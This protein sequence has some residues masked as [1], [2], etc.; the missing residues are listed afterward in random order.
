MEDALILLPRL[1]RALASG[2]AGSDAR[3]D[4]ALEYCNVNSA[5]WGDAEDPSRLWLGRSWAR[6][7]GLAAPAGPWV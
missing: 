5:V 3:G 4:G 1:Q 7:L 6:W 2:G